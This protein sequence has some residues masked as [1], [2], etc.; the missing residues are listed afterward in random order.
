MNKQ[1]LE[2]KMHSEARYLQISI[3]YDEDE[4]LGLINFDNGIE[5]ELQCEEGFVPPM[6]DS[7]RRT[8]EV[9]VD[10]KYRR[11]LNWDEEKGYIHMWAKLCDSGIY[12]LL[13]K[14][15]RPL[16]Q[17]KGYVPN[18]LIP[19][20]ERGFGDY[21][22]LAIR[23]DGSLPEWRKELDFS[24]FLEI[25]KEP[26]QET[27]NQKKKK[28]NEYIFYT[29]EGHST[30]PNEDYEVEHCQMLGMAKGRNELEARKNLLKENPWI[31]EAGFDYTKMMARQL[32]LVS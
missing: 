8:L 24:D 14:E 2:N 27:C 31:E 5:T 12:T 3:P 6:Y 23:P 25:G 21:M 11:V 32:A 28:M 20:Y 19:P 30:A 15:K 18:A 17:K 22:S 9:T 13:D 7:K 16:Y 10:L 4:G 1:A 26:S 29:A